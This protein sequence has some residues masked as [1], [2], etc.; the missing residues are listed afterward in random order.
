MSLGMLSLSAWPIRWRLTVLNVSILVVTLLGLGGVFIF[1]L[2]AALEGIVAEHLRDLARPSLFV[3]QDQRPADAPPRTRAAQGLTPQRA[4]FIVTRLSGPDTGAHVYDDQGTVLA[5]S[6]PSET[7][8]DVGVWPQPPRDLLDTALAG[9]EGRT[10]VNGDAGR[11][12]ML[13]LPIRAAEGNI[14]GVLVL[15]GSL[16]LVQQ[17]EERLRLALAV[18]TLVAAL[19]ASAVGLR[20]TRQALRPLDEVVRV[21]RRIAAG[22]LDVRLRLNRRDEIGQL[23]EAFDSMLDR[24]AAAISAQRR[25]VADAAHELRTPL[26]ALGGM[27]EMLEMGADRG[28]RSTVQRM[29]QT[30]NREIE[31]LTRLVA[32]LLTLSRLDAERPLATGSVDLATLV[33]DVS[34][35]T[36][37]LS[38]GQQV[39]VNLHATPMVQ[40][41]PDQLKQVLINLADNALKFT[42]AD[43]SINFNLDAIDGLASIS[44]VDTGSGIPEAALP[45]VTERFERGDPSRSRSSGG[46]GLGLAIARGIVEAHGGHIAIESEVNR[47]TVVRVTLPRSSANGQIPK[48]A[49]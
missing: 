12:L 10:V 41:D 37:L 48:S 1:L 28:D 9:N 38:H 31:R 20:A 24:V 2:D 45:R 4:T 46:Y 3:L 32:D 23:A 19:L 14:L 49:A 17:L 47:G 5:S 11:T 21:A 26:T 7:L 8:E 33:V 42:P 30:M 22:Q 36:R 39:G 27:V 6:E 35:Q 13:L 16:D 43:G 44:V 40:G 15:D 29:L 34:N 25:F 18:G